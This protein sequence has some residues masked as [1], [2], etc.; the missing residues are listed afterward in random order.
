MNCLV[1]HP[2]FLSTVTQSWNYEGSGVKMY[3]IM[4]KLRQTREHLRRLQKSYTRTELRIDTARKNLDSLQDALRN[5][6][7]SQGLFREV[8]SAQ[9]ELEKWQRVEESILKQRAKVH[10]LRCGDDNSKYFHASLKSRKRNGI[11]V[12]YDSAGTKLIKEEDIELEVLIFYKKLLGSPAETTKAVDINIC[13]SG[14]ILSSQHR[15]SLVRNITR[16]EIKTALQ[17]VGDDKAPGSDGF[18]SKFFK[19]AWEIVGKDVEDAVLDFFSTDNVAILY[20]R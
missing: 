5:N 11:S 16:Q 20:T 12:L 2:D 18:S 13:R 1:D 7:L 6:P 4:Q 17:A 15:T 9:A 10:W 19:G 3:Q 14:P 8:T